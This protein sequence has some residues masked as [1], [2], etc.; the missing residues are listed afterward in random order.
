M[1]KSISGTRTKKGGVDTSSNYSGPI[2]NVGSIRDIEHTQ[3]RL[4]VQSAISRYETVIGLGTNE[5]KIANLDGA[6][7]LADLGDGSIY[8][9]RKYYNDGSIVAKKIKDEASGWAVKTTRPAGHTVVHELAH[10]TWSRY[11]SR[12]GAVNT[13][14]KQRAATVEAGKKIS[15]LY[16]EWRGQVLSKKR[17]SLGEYA[18][19]NADEWFAEYM[20][21]GTIGTKGARRDKYAKALVKIT[22]QYGLKR[23]IATKY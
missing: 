23:G 6:Y 1:P 2:T 20:T 10:Q 15:A 12:D 16:S 7:G 19:T 5:V 14:G 9:N 3:T 21:A 18:T 8:L 4:A 11:A 13:T 22:K 17:K